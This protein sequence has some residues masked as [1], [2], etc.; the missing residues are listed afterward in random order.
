MPP[1][2]RSYLALGGWVSDHAVVDPGLQTMH[3]FTGVEI[4]R[5]RLPAGGCCGP[6][7]ID[8]NPAF[9]LCAQ[10]VWQATWP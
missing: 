8:L 4:G 10:P 5:S 9:A 3:V 6:R 1:L 2:L 7:H